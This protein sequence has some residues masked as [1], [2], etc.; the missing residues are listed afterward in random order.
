[1]SVSTNG[2]INPEFNL[3][4]VIDFIKATP[5]CEFQNIKY[6][7]DYSII[8][9]LYKEE[10]RTMFF[11]GGL[12]IFKSNLISLNKWGEGIEI[13][14]DMCEAFGGIYIQDDCSNKNIELFE[15]IN[16]ANAFYNEGNASY[17]HKWG[18]ANRKIEDST[19]S[20][21]TDAESH[22]DEDLKKIKDK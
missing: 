15:S 16:T 19:I 4:H 18:I 20:D 11:H 13:I 5:E 3:K 14:R 2:H 7:I 17:I 9:F 1:M 10:Q 8:S 22:F 21:I 12:G 6:E